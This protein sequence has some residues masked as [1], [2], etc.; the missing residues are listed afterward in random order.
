MRAIRGVRV[1]HGFLIN[2]HKGL[3]HVNGVVD[4]KSWDVGAQSLFAN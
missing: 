1:H 4:E 2:D 3:H